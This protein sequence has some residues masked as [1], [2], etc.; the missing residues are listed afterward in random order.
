MCFVQSSCQSSNG[1]HLCSAMVILSG[2]KTENI[3]VENFNVRDK[4]PAET[5]ET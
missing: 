3:V 2:I 1:P 4:F 5:T